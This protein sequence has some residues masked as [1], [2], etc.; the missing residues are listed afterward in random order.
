MT[1]PI[2][3]KFCQ[4][5]AEATPYT[6]Y[7]DRHFVF[8]VRMDGTRSNLGW[9]PIWHGFTT[10]ARKAALSYGGRAMYRGQVI[11]LATM[12]SDPCPVHGTIH[13]G[14]SCPPDKR[15]VYDGDEEEYED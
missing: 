11:N 10:A 12:G 13:V 7:E 1:E 5:G 2:D 6:E 9:C 3:P 4:C 15:G 14:G 8:A